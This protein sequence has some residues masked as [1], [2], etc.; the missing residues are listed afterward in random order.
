[1]Y[2]EEAMC[3]QGSSGEAWEKETTWKIQA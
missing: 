1:M 3:K 2:G